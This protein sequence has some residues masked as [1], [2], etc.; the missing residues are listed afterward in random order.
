[1]AEPMSDPTATGEQPP[2]TAVPTLPDF[3]VVTGTAGFRL[4]PNQIRALKAETGKTLTELMG[5]DA[6]DADRMQAAVWLQLRRD[7]RDVRWNE[8]GDIAVEYEEPEPDPTSGE[9]TKSSP[10]SAATGE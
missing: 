1:M 5:D 3:I 4:S 8:C 10:D 9:P 6:D 2:L 7:G